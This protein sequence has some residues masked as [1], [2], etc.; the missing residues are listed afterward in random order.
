MQTLNQIVYEIRNIYKAHA[1]DSQIT[2]R[3]IAQYIKE[4]RAKLLEED[5][6]KGKI[7]S[8]EFVQTLPCVEFEPF[9]FDGVCCNENFTFDTCMMR[10]VEKIPT[11]VQRNAT[12]FITAV[13]AVDLSK[14]YSE[15]SYKRYK[16]NKY[17][18]FTKHSVRW[19]LR[20]G[21]MFLSNT[22]EIKYLSISG[23]FADPEEIGAFTSCE[24][25][26]CFDWD[27]PYPIAAGMVKRVVDIVIKERLLVSLYMK[28]DLDNDAKDK[29]A[30]E[31]QRQPRNQRYV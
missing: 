19:F 26:A 20:N 3:L 24:G 18:R 2:N 12:N 14:D 5:I 27:A 9:N 22:K 16:Y 11:T 4:A 25:N 28:E 8:D 29:E 7:V 17:N 10:S 30:Q 6:S 23:I 21:Y 13:Q 1:D 31:A 15:T